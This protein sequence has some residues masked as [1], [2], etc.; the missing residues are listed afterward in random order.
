MTVQQPA[1]ATLTINDLINKVAAYLQNRQDAT[2]SAT[3]PDMRPSACLR[4]SLREITQKYPFEELRK[5]GPLATIG[6]G[7]GS[8]GSSW[9]YSVSMFLYP[10][11]DMTMSEDPVIF[12]TTAQAQ[13]L[14][15]YPAPTAALLNTSNLVG[16]SMNYLTPKAIQPDL[17]IPGGVP[18]QYTRYG[19]QFWFGSQPGQNYNVYLPYQRKHPFSSKLVE[20]KVYVPEEWFEVVA[21]GAAERLAYKLRWNDQG[22]SLHTMLWG[23]PDYE[24]SGGEEGRPGLI[25]ALTVQPERDRRLSPVVIYPGAQRY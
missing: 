19:N 4:D 9:S 16:Y 12:L 24:K 14:G 7:L 6:P 25:A 21:I 22:M 3:N 17:F 1:S 10:G 5:P 2:E 8:Q 13:S 11:E 18:F 23:D 20:S 15:L